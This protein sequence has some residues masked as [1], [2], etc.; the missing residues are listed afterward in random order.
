[1][2]DF[3]WRTGLRSAVVND[4]N[5]CWPETTVLKTLLLLRLVVAVIIG[6]QALPL[7][8]PLLLPWLP[9]MPSWAFADE[10]RS[11]V[12]VH[13]FP[14]PADD[15]PTATDKG[16]CELMIVGGDPPA[17]RPNF[18][19]GFV[20]AMMIAD[21]DRTALTAMAVGFPADFF[22]SPTASS[23]TTFDQRK[24]PT[25]D[26]HAMNEKEQENNA[27]KRRTGSQSRTG[28]RLP[29]R[30]KRRNSGL[31]EA[32]VFRQVARRSRW[33]CSSNSR[34]GGTTIVGKKRLLFR[35]DD[36]KRRGTNR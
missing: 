27:Q 33:S 28:R 36:T 1:V 34:C 9:R 7:L 31:C 30:N 24:S 35:G 21:G 4:N 2:V 18:A 20:A 6:A 11:I 10:L 16:F 13:L 8:M 19:M 12:F 17:S 3:P 29:H 25:H 5:A 15:A 23:I 22:G 26:T 14:R 32:I